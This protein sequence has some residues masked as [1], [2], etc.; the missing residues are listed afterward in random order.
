MFTYVKKTQ[1]KTNNNNPETPAVLETNQ[2]FGHVF[3]RRTRKVLQ[4]PVGS[5]SC[6]EISIWCIQRG[7][8]IPRNDIS[9]VFYIIPPPHTHTNTPSFGKPAY[10]FFFFLALNGIT[11]AVI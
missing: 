7:S 3:I 10:F 5:D 1:P 6:P 9:S 4:R 8:V 2:S 11:R